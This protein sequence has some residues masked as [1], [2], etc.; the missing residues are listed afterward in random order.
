[1]QVR[2]QVRAALRNSGNVHA[3]ALA[4]VLLRSGYGMRDAI[5]SK[6]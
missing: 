1:M 5:G 2:M 4:G 3:D 6:H